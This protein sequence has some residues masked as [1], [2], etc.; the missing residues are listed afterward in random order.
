VASTTRSGVAS[1]WSFPAGTTYLNHG[2]FGPSPRCVQEAREELQR[3]LEA[4]PM[5]FFLRQL[6]PL[7]IAARARLAAFV[8]AAADDLVFVDNATV[9][10]NVVAASVALCPGDEVLLNDH[11]YG[12]V[13]RI[14]ERRCQDAGAKVVVQRLPQP[15]HT[16]DELADAI[17]AGASD[18]TRLL[19][20]SHVT[21]PTAVILPAAVICRRARAAGIAVCID[22][23]HAVA[24]LPLDVASLDCDFYAASCHKW[25]SAP[26]GSG[27]LYV[28]PRRQAAVRPAIVSWGRTLEGDSPSWR[29]EFHW[30]GTRDTTAWLAV[31]AAIDFLEGVGLN[32]FRRET[33]ELA[34]YARERIGELTAEVAAGRAAGDL[35]PLTPDEPVWYGSMAAMP[36]PPGEAEPLM[37]ALWERHGIEVPIIDWSG[38]RLIR[39]SCHVYNTRADVDRLVGALKAEIA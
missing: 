39:V 1:Q 20:F 5:D 23:P 13:L 3:R 4:Q 21:S 6:P 26:F 27:V 10:M 38:R 24:M 35:E 31:P 12:A 17:F 11:E 32:E 28:H 19:V 30:L 33:H 34:R 15:V 18:R 37:R 9:G 16:A 22:G 25:L 14:W 36:L 2:S 7:L 8:G 29:D